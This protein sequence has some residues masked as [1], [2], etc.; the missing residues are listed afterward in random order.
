MLPSNTTYLLSNPFTPFHVVGC[1]VHACLKCVVRRNTM[2]PTISARAITEQDTY[3]PYRN[4]HPG[5][6]PSQV[7]KLY[8]HC[9]AHDRDEVQ[10]QNDI[11]GAQKWNRSAARKSNYM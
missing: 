5:N 10:S 11:S 9:R 8:N 2:H 7:T 1:F 6:V 4:I 3:L